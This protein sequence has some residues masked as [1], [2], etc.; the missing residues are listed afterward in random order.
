MVFSGGNTQTTLEFCSTRTN[1][2]R[3][4]ALSTRCISKHPLHTAP[5]FFFFGS[6]FFPLATSFF[7]HAESTC[8]SSQTNTQCSLLLLSQL[9]ISISFIAYIASFFCA[10]K[11]QLFFWFAIF[12]FFVPVF[13][14]NGKWRSGGGERGRSVHRTLN[15]SLWLW[16]WLFCRCS[17]CFTPSCAFQMLFAACRS[18]HL[19]LHILSLQVSV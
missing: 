1:S 6:L 10:K 3:T 13:F 5:F 15:C 19:C 16:L 14:G 2:R 18:R 8:S 11:E 9:R 4:R 12:A 7:F 17:F